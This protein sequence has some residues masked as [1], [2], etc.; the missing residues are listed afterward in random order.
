MDSNKYISAFFLFFCLL[1]NV[2]VSAEDIDFSS[3]YERIFQIRVVSPD[4]GSKSSIGSGFQVS[5]DGLIMTN[6]HVVSGYVNSPDSYEIKYVT[7]DGKKGVLELLDFDVIADL[8]ILRHPNPVDDFFSLNTQ[9]IEKGVTAYALG[10]PGD[11]GIIMVPGPTNGFVE[12]SYEEQVLF[13]GSLNPGMSGGPSLNAVGEVIGVNVA[14]AGSQLSFL[15]PAEKAV[16][17]LK[18]D[19]H[20]QV[21]DYK[22]EISEQIKTWQLPRVTGLLEKAWRDENFASRQLFGEIRYDFQCWGDTNESNT[23]RSVAVVSKTCSAGDRVYL[24][25]DLDAGQISFSFR[26]SKPI[27]YNSLQ[28]AKLQ[29]T[30]MAADNSSRF[31]H[32]TNYVCESSFIKAKGLSDSDSNQEGYHRVIT[33]IRAYKNLEGLYDSLLLFQH[34]QAKQSFNAH[35]SLSALKKDQINALNKRFIEEVL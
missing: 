34:H 24:A 10:N 9:K 5:A 12:H 3:D 14:S 2:G 21:I 8:A 16:N 31:D 13:S 30:V 26:N 22:K 4:A 29:R 32:S 35:L 27:K 17:L 20:L 28:F 11:W 7:H 33:C 15:V 23:D 25:H 19:R 6:Y 1:L 18:R